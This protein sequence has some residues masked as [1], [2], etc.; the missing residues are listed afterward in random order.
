MRRATNLTL[1]ETKSRGTISFSRLSYVEVGHVLRGWTL[2]CSN[3]PPLF[4][5]MIDGLR[6][7][8]FKIY[9]SVC[10][11]NIDMTIFLHSNSSEVE[12]YFHMVGNC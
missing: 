5:V 6:I 3:R 2:L 4:Y 9:I 10:S 8:I 7:P 11:D 1:S 12:D